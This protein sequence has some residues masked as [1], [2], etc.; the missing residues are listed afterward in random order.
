MAALPSKA[1]VLGVHSARAICNPNCKPTA[2]D[3]MVL[4]TTDQDGQQKNPERERTL[5]Y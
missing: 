3:W 5:S 2:R 4:D 1:G